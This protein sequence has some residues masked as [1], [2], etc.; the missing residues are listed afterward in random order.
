[1]EGHPTKHLEFLQVSEGHQK[2]RAGQGIHT[3]NH[4]LGEDVI[5]GQ[6]GQKLDETSSQPTS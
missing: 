5:Q 2:E 4:S 1:M 3:Y 6:P